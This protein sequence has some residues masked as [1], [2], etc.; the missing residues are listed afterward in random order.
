[1][2][3][4]KSSRK[5]VVAPQ[6]AAASPGPTAGMSLAERVSWYAL[7][8]AV[9]LVPLAFTNATWLGFQLP[10]T[11][12]QFDIVKVF[13]MRACALIALGGWSWHMLSKGGKIR[14]TPLAWLVLA[15]LAW[16]ALSAVFSI[17]PP[18][19]IFGKY[20]RFEGLLSF[21]TYAVM[22]FLTLQ[23]VDRPSRIKQLIQSLFWSSVV[24][25][26]YGLLQFAGLDIIKWGSLPFEARRSFSTYGNPDLLG[27]FLVISLPISAA[28]ALS[29]ERPVWRAVWWTGLLINV[30][31]WITAFTRGAWIGGLVGFALLG[32]FAWRQRARFDKVVDVTFIVLISVVAL[33]LIFSS[34][35]SPDAVM[36][37]SKRVVSIFEF[38]SGSGQSRFQIWE[39]AINATKDRPIFG[40]GADTFRLVFPKY[41]TVEYVRT[42]GHLSVADNVHNYPLQL[43]AGIGIPGALMLYAI[44]AWAAVASF[45][46]IFRREDRVI[47]SRMMLAGF[48]CA[49]AAYI[50]HLFFGISV[51]GTSVLLWIAMGVVVAPTA[52]SFEFK[53]P[54]GAEIAGYGV[55]ALLAVGLA[56]NGI[57]IAADNAYLKAKVLPAGPDRDAFAM[58]AVKLNP[59]NDMYRADVGTAYVDEFF[60]LLSQAQSVQDPQQR[61]LYLRGAQ[62]SFQN[63]ESAFND[64]IAY[65]PAEY[66]NYVFLTNLY[67]VAGDYLGPQ[68]Y[69]QAVD[70]G[71]RGVAAEPL[72][73]AIR[74]QLAGA[75]DRVEQSK[76]ARRQL[77]IALSMDPKYA[78]AALALAKF[79]E[80]AG[81]LEKAI[82][83]LKSVEK[84]SPG[85]TGVA[86][87]IKRLEASATAQ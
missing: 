80:D 84:R 56:F 26:G 29:E 39:A 33:A 82:S 28:L 79:Y 41:K 3:K 4:T 12:D 69:R 31:V 25:A 49:C 58:R 50:T 40:F 74:F 63:A 17:H 36:N 14:W 76:E 8:A 86:E 53:P 48:W 71:R 11:F 70:V 10:F 23:F 22:F 73:P 59:Y 81:Q 42:V 65:V 54:K 57:Y 67:V 61:E 20:R 51:T 30:M 38:E 19:A 13:V 52:T 47:P 6:T 68:Y 15:F 43:A 60:Q 9:F 1:M 34:L 75:L 16:V 27:G 46:T 78:S 72:G 5:A 7:V 64:V 62:Q 24:V 18:T 87:E 2:A 77:E 44:F 32:V 83:V 35:K 45:K 66:D 21:I 37:F 85:Q 55:V